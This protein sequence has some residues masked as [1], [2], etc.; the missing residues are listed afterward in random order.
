MAAWQTWHEHHAAFDDA[1]ADEDQLAF[2]F[3][4]NL[5]SPRSRKKLMR[6][7][8]SISKKRKA[9]LVGREFDLLVTGE[10]DETDMLWEGR[11]E[12]HA[13]EIDGKVYI[14]DFGARE[15]LTPGEFVRCE[16]IESHDYDLVA[17]II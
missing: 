7:Q 1:Q 8:Q 13:P 6:I 3:G 12:M 17:R 10:S 14:S 9:E 4:P 11:T 5:A 2:A 16:I 15:Q